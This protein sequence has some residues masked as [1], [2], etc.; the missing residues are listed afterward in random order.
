MK[1]NDS[2][3]WMVAVAIAAIALLFVIFNP[4]EPPPQPLPEAAK[5]PPPA[6]GL[7][8][9]E[10][11]YAPGR[12]A[13]PVTIPPAASGT[14]QT[15]SPSAVLP[16]DPDSGPPPLLPPSKPV[17][18]NESREVVDRVQ[19]V[20]RDYRLA[21]GGNPVG[22]NAEITRALLG[23][24]VKQVKFTVPEGS[25]L[26]GQGEMCDP[27]GTPYF[28]HAVSRDRMEIRSAGPDRKMWTGDDV[29]L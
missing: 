6:V 21:L 16:S 25:Q 19:F 26:N 9:A 29:Q 4:V 2:G 11:R 20:I 8:P 14:P 27:W 17:D 5:A 7:P 3:L 12:N 18:R 23:D 15:Q 1:A 10:T 13:D 24:N 22:D 28:F